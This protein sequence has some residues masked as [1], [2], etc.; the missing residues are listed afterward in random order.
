MFN[1]NC[2]IIKSHLKTER[3]ALNGNIPRFCPEDIFCKFSASPRR[4]VWRFRRE[5]TLDDRLSTWTRNSREGFR[6][7]TSETMPDWNWNLKLKRWNETFLNL[8]E[9]FPPFGCLFIQQPL[10]YSPVISGERGSN[11]LPLH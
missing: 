6:S 1:T 10:F 5:A 2:K 11:S 4:D 7:G 8:L 3:L 9:L